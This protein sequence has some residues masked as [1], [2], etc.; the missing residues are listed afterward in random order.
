MKTDAPTID[1]GTDDAEAAKCM[2][3]SAAPSIAARPR[4]LNRFLTGAWLTDRRVYWL[5]FAAA[6]VNILLIMAIQFMQSFQTPRGDGMHLDFA[7][8]WATSALTLQGTPAL[9]YDL[10]TTMQLQEEAARLSGLADMPWIYPPVFQLI[11]IPLG[12]MPMMVAKIV[13][14]LVTCGLYLAVAWRILPGRG[15][16]YAALAPS[17]VL[18]LFVSGQAGFL[19]AAIVGVGLLLWQRRPVI[20]GVAFGLMCIKPQLVVAGLLAAIADRRWTVIV[21]ALITATVFCALS[22]AILGIDTW[23]AFPKGVSHAT[24]YFRSLEVFHFYASTSG[25]LRNAGVGF[26]PSMVT[27]VVVSLFAGIVLIKG[28]RDPRLSL[29]AK[30]SLLAYG[31]IAASPRVMDYDLLIIFLGALFQIRHA[32][33]R[34]FFAGERTVLLLAMFISWLDFGLPFTQLTSYVS[35]NGV[36]PPMMLAALALGERYRPGNVT[37][38]VVAVPRPPLPTRFVVQAAR[39]IRFGVVGVAATATHVLVLSGLIEL[40]GIDPRFANIAAFMVAVPVSYLG[41]YYWSFGSVHPHGETL[42]RFIVVAVSS[43]LGSQGLMLFAL[44]ILGASYWVGVALMVVVMPLVNF[45]VQQALVFR[46]RP[47]A[48]REGD[49]CA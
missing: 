22:L 8:F 2:P 23:T 46:R 27:Q 18:F 43:L 13:W 6:V 4:P 20:A 15:T 32:K 35:I 42:L 17:P 14:C 11:V 19:T 5:A 29:D 12:M 49:G 9:A 39:L 24:S 1:A 16:L 41:H 38:L 31:M 26:G 7:V 28:F 45:A 34:G 47:T 44:D 21:S 30:S 37:S 10:E 33:V 36:I 3:K 48:A 25:A 40:A